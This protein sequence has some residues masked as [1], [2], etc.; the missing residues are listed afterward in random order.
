MTAELLRGSKTSA[1]S[2]QWMNSMKSESEPIERESGGRIDSTQIEIPH[3]ISKQTGES[4]D[5]VR[6]QRSSAQP[7][8]SVA[9]ALVLVRVV[10]WPS[11]RAHPC[12]SVPSFADPCCSVA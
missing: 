8:Y 2:L 4:C 10:S 5:G 11:F 6:G 3:E 9:L 12:C 7:R 1:R